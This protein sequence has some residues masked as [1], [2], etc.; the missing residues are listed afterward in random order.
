MIVVHP[1]EAPWIAW[2]LFNDRR[3]GMRMWFQL[4][5]P[6]IMG[7]WYRFPWCGWKDFWRARPWR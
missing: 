5:R 7:P 6:P 2:R 3:Q 4:L 1:C